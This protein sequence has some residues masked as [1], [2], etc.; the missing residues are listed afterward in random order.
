MDPRRLGTGLLLLVFV[1]VL[2]PAPARATSQVP[3]VLVHGLASNPEHAFGRPGEAGSLYQ[4][5]INKGYVLGQTLFV[6]DY[7]QDN[8]ASYVDICHRY[9]I[10]VIQQ[11]KKLSG[12]TSVDVV[13]HSMGCLVARYYINSPQYGGDVRTLV[14]LAP[15]GRGSFGANLARLLVFMQYAQKT[16]L[17]GEDCEGFDE[18][19][20]VATRANRHRQWFEDFFFYARLLSATPR[21]EAQDYGE[22][23]IREQ[24][25]FYRNAFCLAQRPLLRADYVRGL[26]TTHPE[27]GTDL[28]AAYYEAA[29]AQVGRQYYLSHRGVKGFL[30]SIRPSDLFLSGKLT[31]W[32][33]VKVL[34]VKAGRQLLGDI[35]RRLWPGL[36]A[37]GVAHF[38]QV[39]PASE[40]VRCLLEE[41]VQLPGG[42]E[43][44]LANYFLWHWNAQE[45][46]RRSSEDLP[47][48]YVT[49][50][51]EVFNV[52]AALYDTVSANDAIVETAATFLP[53]YRDDVFKLYQGLVNLNHFAL[54]SNRA[55]QEFITQQLAGC[56]AAAVHH[57]R[58]QTD[59]WQGKAPASLWEP[60]Y[61]EFV[62][63][64]GL[65]AAGTVQIKVDCL[66]M[67]HLAGR[68]PGITG[69]GV[70]TWVRVWDGQGQESFFNQ[71]GELPLEQGWQRVRVGCRLQAH[72]LAPENVGACYEVPGGEFSCQMNWQAGSITSP[73][74]V[75]SGPELPGG[76]TVPDDIPLI[77]VIRHSKLTTGKK[78]QR[79]FHSRWEWDFGDGE[80]MVD[81]DPTHIVT[82]VSHSFA[83]PGTYRVRATSWANNGRA[84]REM[85]WQVEILTGGEQRVFTAETIQEPQVEIIINGPDQWITG[86]PALFTVQAIVNQPPYTHNQQVQIYPAPRFQ[87]VWAR[88]GTFDVVVAVTV[89]QSYRFPN[90]S[91]FVSN[92]YLH[93]VPVKVLTTG[94]TD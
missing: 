91:I 44:F 42:S 89:R 17:G 32:N 13:A 71:V 14:R 36:A 5:L 57:V 88:A 40:A 90:Q 39:D 52:W 87:V 83:L 43:S 81:D 22:W 92:T 9:L 85:S 29:A 55:V 23:L 28:T 15:P 30:V 6:C 3:V 59:C 34:V 62:P 79:T 21:T 80:Q 48:R 38:L 65:G 26:P 31:F 76:I 8:Q 84:L 2:L 93:K 56:Q 37:R 50:A 70:E 45:A 19:A 94:V 11:A 33:A 20:Y 61:F 7:R 86:R 16:G 24:P 18:L 78:E 27:P 25:E 47:V 10:P 68:V 12:A 4:H 41:E 75:D 63:Q 49:V 67:P 69:V 51:G 1:S 72:G 66:N 46:E 77:Q 73:V 74:P 53:L 64:D 58:G 82:E 54:R 60:T 35:I